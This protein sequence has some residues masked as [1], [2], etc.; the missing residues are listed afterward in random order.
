VGGREHSWEGIF[1]RGAAQLGVVQGKDEFKFFASSKRKREMN[2]T[3]R[4]IKRKTSKDGD[5]TILS[6]YNKGGTKRAWGLCGRLVVGVRTRQR[7][8][9][10]LLRKEKKSGQHKA[11]HPPADH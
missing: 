1:C 6:T 3:L 2:S 4:K 9:Q 10:L 11:L 8:G 5:I 7:Q